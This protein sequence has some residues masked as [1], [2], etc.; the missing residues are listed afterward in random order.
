MTTHN[1]P[2]NAPMIENRTAAETL[3]IRVRT[4]EMA[5]KAIPVSAARHSWV[6]NKGTLPP[7]CRRR[8]A[9]TMS[10]DVMSNASIDMIG[11]AGASQILR[12]GIS[13]HPAIAA[14]NPKTSPDCDIG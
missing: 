2:V 12:C 14:K 3:S 11:I 4:S 9:W 10:R 5:I 6:T 8:S 13:R 1:A 7:S